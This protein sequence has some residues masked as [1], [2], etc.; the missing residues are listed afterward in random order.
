[1]IAEVGD[2]YVCLGLKYNFL[3]AIEKISF[4]SNFKQYLRTPLV[5]HTPHIL[6]S[7]S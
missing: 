3:L 5:I 7:F 1:M 4:R 2:N 6:I